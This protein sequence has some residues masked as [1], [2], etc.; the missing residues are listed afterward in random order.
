MSVFL[1]GC[2]DTKRNCWVTVTKVHT[3]H[4][5]S[6]LEQLQKELGPLMVKISQEYIKIPQWLDCNK[7]MVPDFIAKDP[8]NQPVWEITGWYLFI[9]YINS[10]VTVCALY[11]VHKV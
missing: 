3:G 10:F 9:I 4:D 1:M 5:D 2:L 8:K 7:G 11:C 6:T